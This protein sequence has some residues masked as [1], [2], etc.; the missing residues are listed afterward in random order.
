VIAA[1]TAWRCE[2][3][4]RPI[5]DLNSAE[6]EAF[7]QTSV[8]DVHERRLFGLSKVLMLLTGLR[9][10]AYQIYGRDVS[11]LIGLWTSAH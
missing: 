1:T 5:G 11:D 6:I 7:A 2:Q 9:K 3:A 8:H 10:Q 4:E